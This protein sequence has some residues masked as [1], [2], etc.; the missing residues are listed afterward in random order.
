MTCCY[1]MS[2]SSTE[3][4]VGLA[5][6]WGVF[7]YQGEP[8]ME[9]D[10]GAPECPQSG[11][12]IPL[13]PSSA[14]WWLCRSLRLTE[15]LGLCLC[16]TKWWVPSVQRPCAEGR[17]APCEVLH[18]GASKCWWSCPRARYRQ[19]KGACDQGRGC[20]QRAWAPAGVRPEQA[21]HWGSFSPCMS[22]LTPRAQPCPPE[23]V[24]I[25]GLNQVLDLQSGS[26]GTLG[27]GKL[28]ISCASCCP[29]YL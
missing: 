17:A 15:G 24:V 4:P 14:P 21:C 19:M 26:A 20:G 12:A 8:R 28:G 16:P 27:Q 10:K 23:S 1:D 18:W 5:W 6:W 25:M 9:P 2:L 11:F 3:L 13:A 7:Q 29:L 22:W